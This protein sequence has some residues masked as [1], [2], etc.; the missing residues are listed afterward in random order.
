MSQLI[1][2]KLGGSLLTD[3]THEATPRPEVI[4]RLAQ[5]VAAARRQSPHLRLLVGH[6]SGSFGHAAGQHYRT[7]DGVWN[8][9][10]WRGF[11]ETAAAA[12]RLN[13]LVVDALLA[14]GLPAWSLQPS[15]SARCHDGQL[16]NLDMQPIVDALAHG[17]V[18]VVY[19]DVALDEV[20]GGTIVSTEE[21]FVWLAPRLH[22][23]RIVLAG[24]VDGVYSADP[25]RSGEAVRFS[26][27]TP[28]DVA[29][30]GSSLGGS[31]GIDVT[32]GMLAKV[33]LMASMVTQMPDL[34]VRLLSGEIPGRLIHA[35]I[36][37]H[38]DEGTVLRAVG[39]P[40]FYK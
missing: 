8:E 28:Q 21:L 20:R 12:A 36:A 22:P 26:H 5:E 38:W 3:K 10:G 32:G 25:L 16:I 34:E 13:R 24:A 19:G 14:A 29:R 40:C 33:Q 37:E 39:S 31:H 7:R 23:A 30:L 6:G 4:A 17:L 15:A 11:V 18:P 2:I 27:L 1:F 9:A 35:I